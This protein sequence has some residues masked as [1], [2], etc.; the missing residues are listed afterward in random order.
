MVEQWLAKKLLGKDYEVKERMSRGKMEVKGWKNV[1]GWKGVK[2]WTNFKDMNI[3]MF[4]LL[5]C[6][7]NLY[8]Q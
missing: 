2:G 1:K 7:V 5:M 8:I 6:G 4:S 3:F